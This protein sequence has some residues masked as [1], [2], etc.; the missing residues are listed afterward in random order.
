[1]GTTE[2]GTGEITGSMTF[3]IIGATGLSLT[4]TN[5]T[6]MIDTFTLLI[7]ATAC[8]FFE[9]PPSQAACAA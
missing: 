9:W 8:I 1:M 2:M 7:S 5:A 6:K 4:D 3:K